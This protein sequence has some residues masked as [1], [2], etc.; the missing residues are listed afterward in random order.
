MTEYTVRVTCDCSI[1][2]TNAK[3]V[4][5]A[6]PLAAAIRPIAAKGLGITARNANRASK[7]HGIVYFAHDPSLAG[8][9][10][11]RLSVPA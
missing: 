8:F 10:G 1:C 11:P 6:F 5:A 2:E 4:G 3:R 7:V 9:S